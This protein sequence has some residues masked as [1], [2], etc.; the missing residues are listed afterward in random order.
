MLANATTECQD[1]KTLKADHHRATRTNNAVGKE[2]DGFAGQVIGVGSKLT[3]I[4]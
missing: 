1:I 2:R 3:H 4:S